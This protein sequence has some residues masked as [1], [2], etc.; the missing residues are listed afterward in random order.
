MTNQEKFI[1]VMNATFGAGFSKEN[2]KT[3]CSPCGAMKKAEY[4]CS[5]FFCEGCVAWWQKEYVGPEEESENGARLHQNPFINDPFALVWTAFKNLYPDLECDCYFDQHQEDQ[6]DEEYGFTHF[7]DDGSKPSVFVYAEHSV[8]TQVETFAHEL[9]HIAV[10]PEHEH[11]D[12]WEAAL[13]A[14]FTE[15][16]RIG[17]ELF[18]KASGDEEEAIR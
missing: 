10:G 5:R 1:E 18:G 9:A 12:V 7:P 15:Y 14:I 16:N 13:D 4:G 8:N 17:D 3:R 2:M 11:N 6:H